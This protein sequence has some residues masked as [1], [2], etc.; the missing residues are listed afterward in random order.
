M[1]TFS[2]FSRIATAGAV[3]VFA[4]ATGAQAQGTIAIGV[5]VP[6][7][8]SEA[9]YGKDMANAVA[10][11]QDEINKKGGVLGKKLSMIIGDSACDP[12]QSVNAATKLVSQGVVGVVGGYCSGA[13]LPEVG[14]KAVA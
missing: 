5:Q 1:R 14:L 6:T 10:I 2:M 13:T 8:G 7:T 11:A 12:Q 9:T 3:L 4:V